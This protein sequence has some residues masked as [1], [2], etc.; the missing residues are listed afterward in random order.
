M[1]GRPSGAQGAMNHRV[2]PYQGQQR[3]EIT[4]VSDCQ[5]LII[6]IDPSEN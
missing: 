6:C 4:L 5:P 3:T 1:M 2:G